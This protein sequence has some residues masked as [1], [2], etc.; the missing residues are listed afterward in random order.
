MKAF[1]VL[2][3]TILAFGVVYNTV[4]ISLSERSRE[5]ATL[6]VLGFTRREVSAILLGELAVLTLIAIPFG[7][8]LGYG[9]AA[10]TTLTL[11]TEIYRIPLIVD[12]STF[13]FSATV[14][15]IAALVS[16]LV[17]RRKLD[18][19]DLVAVLKARE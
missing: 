14:I 2:F 3:A 18:H 4:R 11:D 8:V 19:L 6:R 12:R 16:G 17:V 1:N 9:F 13:A 10:L 15:M 7:L 5:F